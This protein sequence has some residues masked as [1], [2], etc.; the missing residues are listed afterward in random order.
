MIIS[1]LP[2]IVNAPLSLSPIPFANEYEKVSPGLG[3]FV[4]KDATIDP[5]EIFSLKEVS[6]TS[7][8]VGEVLSPLLLK[9]STHSG[10]TEIPKGASSEMLTLFNDG[11]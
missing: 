9:I 8:L 4:F 1:W 5:L 6:E 3:S 10:N 7:R 2:L 11:L